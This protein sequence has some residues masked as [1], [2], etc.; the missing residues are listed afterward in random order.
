MRFIDFGQINAGEKGLML[1]RQQPME[2]SMSTRDLINRF[3]PS[4]IAIRKGGNPLRELQEEVNKLFHDFF[5]D[6]S[7]PHWSTADALKASL[8]VDV[9]ENDKEI[10]ITAEVPGMEAKDVQVLAGDGYLTI[11][12]EKKEETKADN[13]NYH[14]HERLYGSYQR[15]IAMPDAAEVGKAQASVRNGIL[16]IS[17]PKNEQKTAKEQRIEVK[18]AA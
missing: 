8:A 6:L 11:K 15:I 5:G 2:I 17:I 12:G 10:T 4:N 13:D 7:W 16:R 18:Q 1:N 3:R 14:C 9:S